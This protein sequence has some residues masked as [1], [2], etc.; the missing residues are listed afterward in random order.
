MIDWKGNGV[1]EYGYNLLK[2]VLEMFICEFVILNDK[3]KHFQ[4]VGGP[5]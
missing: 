4:M 5:I 3:S 2:S 1:L